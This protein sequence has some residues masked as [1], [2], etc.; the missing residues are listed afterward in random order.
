MLAVGPLNTEKGTREVFFELNGE[1][2][3]SALWLVLRMEPG[4]VNTDG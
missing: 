3:Y 4:K 1:V 2:G